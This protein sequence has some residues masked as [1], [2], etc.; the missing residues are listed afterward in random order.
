MEMDPGLQFDDE[1][2]ISFSRPKL[3]CKEFGEP[4]CHGGIERNPGNKPSFSARYPNE[5]SLA[6]SI[7][8]KK[9]GMKRGRVVENQESH[10]EEE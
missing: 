10:E 7:P 9:N 2:Q 6:I 5:L 1:T 3:S 4:S 8:M